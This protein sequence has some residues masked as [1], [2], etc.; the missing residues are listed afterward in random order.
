MRNQTIQERGRPLVPSR[1]VLDGIMFVLRTGCHWKM[2]PTEYISGSICHRRFQE[3]VLGDIFDRIWK[4]LLKIYDTKRGI[5]F[6]QI[7]INILL[8]TAIPSA[9]T[10]MM[11]LLQLIQL[12]A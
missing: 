4:R 1:K 6:L 11:L 8:S 9:N 7:I 5:K 2:L 3:W 10:L 12:T